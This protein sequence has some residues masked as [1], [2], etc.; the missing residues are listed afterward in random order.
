[1]LFR[2]RAA[3]QETLRR[4]QTHRVAHPDD[5]RRLPEPVAGF[6]EDIYQQLV[7]LKDYLFAQVYHDPRTRRMMYKGRMILRQLFQA[8]SEH[9]ELLP[10]AVQEQLGAG[11]N[12]FRV[13]CDYLSSMTDR[14]AMDLYDTLFQPYE[15]S[16]QVLT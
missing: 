11:E 14:H 15:R 7:A 13:V 10:R 3:A 1:M 5:V 6:P 8:F 9:P 16:L 4:L 12:R 2:S